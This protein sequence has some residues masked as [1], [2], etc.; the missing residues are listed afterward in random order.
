MTRQLY[1]LAVSEEVFRNI[2]IGSTLWSRTR[3]EGNL[4]AEGQTHPA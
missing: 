1:D 3:S 4:A 2:R